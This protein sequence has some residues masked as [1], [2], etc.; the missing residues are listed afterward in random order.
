MELANNCTPGSWGSFH[1]LGEHR[2]GAE[3]KEKAANTWRWL[4]QET[5]SGLGSITAGFLAKVKIDLFTTAVAGAPGPE[6][7]SAPRLV[8]VKLRLSWIN[9]SS[10]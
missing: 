9:G 2:P 7:I 1:L 6:P 5:S 8:A 4:F 3:P 10:T